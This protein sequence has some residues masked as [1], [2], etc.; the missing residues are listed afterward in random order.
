[1]KTRLLIFFIITQMGLHAQLVNTRDQHDPDI[2]QQVWRLTEVMFHDVVNPPAAARFYAYSLLAGYEILYQA[3]TTIVSFYRSL[4]QYP[5]IRTTIDKSIVN[6]ELAVQY[7]IL[8]TG[9]AIIPSGYL[10]EA[11]QQQLID[12]FK[13][14]KLSKEI[15]DASIG[16]AEEVA[17]Q[18]IQFAKSDGYFKLSTR[19]RYKPLHIQGS[20]QPTAPE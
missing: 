6:K 3:D 5:A 1:M 7:G 17:M 2:Q 16:L 4:V 9:K 13:K 18:I 8:E 19:L 15:I 20:W 11:Y 10:L 12:A 14:K